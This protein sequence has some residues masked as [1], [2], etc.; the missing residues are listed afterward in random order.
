[1]VEEQQ[2]LHHAVLLR[3]LPELRRLPTPEARREV[4][5]LARREVDKHW[6]FWVGIVA[7]VVADVVI[8][9]LLPR[10]GVPM[11]WRGT[12]RG[13]LSAAAMIACLLLGWSFRKTIRR[14]LWR[15]L[16]SRHIPCCTSCGYDLTGNVSGRCP[17]CGAKV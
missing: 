15:E 3:L 16:A 6:A 13:L 1:M 14:S 7:I 9:F 2:L 8:T 4:L 12:T 11:P 5:R 17:E 10:F